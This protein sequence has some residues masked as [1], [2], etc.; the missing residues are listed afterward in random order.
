MES[1]DLLLGKKVGL[2]GCPCRVSY[3][4]TGLEAFADHVKGDRVDA[5][6]DGCHV[7]ADVVQ[8]QKETE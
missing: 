1:F 4:K 5:R 7:D 8:H 3:P 2:T 6:V